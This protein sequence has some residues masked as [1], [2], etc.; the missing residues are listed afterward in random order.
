MVKSFTQLRKKLQEESWGSTFK[1]TINNDYFQNNL[2][3]IYKICLLLFYNLSLFFLPTVRQVIPTSQ[4]IKI[5]KTH[6]K[7]INLTGDDAFLSNLYH[8]FPL[9]I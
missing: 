3:S 4:V 2:F 5:S 8:F 9:V 6:H 7:I 1:K